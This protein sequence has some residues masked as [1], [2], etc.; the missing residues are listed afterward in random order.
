ME[1]R[2]KRNRSALASAAHISASAL[3]QYVRG[4]ATP[5]LAVLV[6]LAQALEVS[7]DF[8]VYGQ[9]ALSGGDHAAWAQHRDDT[10]RHM[11]SEAASLLQFV[12]RVGI[13][14]TA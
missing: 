2:Y 7:L 8:F 9:D 14:I 3:S 11:T 1:Q 10:V 13:E 12:G 5:S 4:R 6:D